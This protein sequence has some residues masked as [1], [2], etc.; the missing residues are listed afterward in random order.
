MKKNI[1]AV[2]L[3]FVT[4]LTLSTT[5][6]LAADATF[7][8]TSGHWAESAIDTWSE[9]GVLLGSDGEFRPNAPITRA[10]LAAVLNRVMGYTATTDAAFTDVTDG[11][12]YA[13]DISKV[14]AAGIMLGDGDGVMRPTE[15]I[16][17]EEA[18]VMIARAFS[19]EEN[20]GNDNPFPDAAEISGWASL[21]VDGLRAKGY[22]NGDNEGNFNPKAYITRAEVVTILDNIVDAFYNAPGDYENL[23]VH[24]VVVQSEG[25]TL[26]NATISGN[27]YIT[28]GVGD[29]DVT[30]D[31]VTVA[32]T[33]YVRG[34]GANSLHFNN[35]DIAELIVTKTH[36]RVVLASGS[37]VEH[38]L[39][40]TGDGIFEIIG[41]TKI[42]SVTIIGEGVTLKLSEGA[43][44]GTINA[45]AGNTRVETEIGTSIDKVNLNGST[46]ITGGGTIAEANIAV[47][48]CT[49]EQKPQNTSV[50]GGVTVSI[51]GEEVTDNA[52]PPSNNSSDSSSDS[53]G[54]SSGGS[55]DS[56][57]AR[58][59]APSKTDVPFGTTF[60]ELDL[61]EN[62]TLYA[63]TGKT[64][65]VSVVWRENT[66]DPFAS[67]EQKV[68]GDVSA[69]LALPKWVPTAITVTVTVRLQPIPETLTILNELGETPL[70]T[71]VRGESRKYTAKVLDQS[72]LVMSEQTVAWSISPEVSGVSVSELGQVSVAL[73]SSATSFTLKA[74]CGEAQNT[75]DIEITEPS[76]VTAPQVTGLTLM[77]GGSGVVYVTWTTPIS[78][79]YPV[80]YWCI[81]YKDGTEISRITS[82]LTNNPNYKWNWEILDRLDGEPGNY[83]IEVVTT[84][85]SNHALNSAPVV[86]D[87]T[88]VLEEL[89]A[90]PVDRIVY[91]GLDSEYMSFSGHLENPQFN[92]DYS[93]FEHVYIDFDFGTGWHTMERVSV[94]LDGTFEFSIGLDRDGSGGPITIENCYLRIC[95]YLPVTDFSGDSVTLFMTPYTEVDIE[96]QP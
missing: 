24:N 23:G 28:E 16:T 65:Y 48:G 21:L 30:L 88:L 29:G 83:T 14:Y 54:D 32:G 4:L 8:D 22:I 46:D 94:N 5:V 56:A 73:E 13:E 52:P 41:N 72:G 45:D 18:A 3:A 39:A 84:N 59:N 35:C 61:P 51:G 62:V 34:G 75:F 15:N 70:D 86:C 25:V 67:G 53:S 36:V 68:T 12:W 82:G 90:S 66:Y 74:V 31:N 6:V 40:L 89:D 69:D 64:A 95:R 20:A 80:V 1:M 9:H 49:I 17:R 10:E 87:K 26:K 50:D 63:N 55:P 78:V 77:D 11:E 92:D 76:G 27:L 2:L 44:I 79:P 37:V 33:T 93:L 38:A 85:P 57:F 81:I 7:S 19:V 91:N 96:P 42:E 43:S 60:S 71:L 47:D 58:H